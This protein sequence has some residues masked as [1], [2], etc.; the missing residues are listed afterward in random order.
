MMLAHSYT[1]DI[2]PTG[3][4][5]SEKMDGVR[6]YWDGTEL[7]SRLGNRIH[8]PKWFTDQ[9]PPY[10]HLDGELWG[11][12][13]NF[14][15]T[16]SIVRSQSKNEEWKHVHY[17]VFDSPTA[18]GGFEERLDHAHESIKGS[19]VASIVPQE[20]CYDKE[21]LYARLKA[22][23]SI[24]AEGLMLRAPAS[25]YESKR[26]HFLLKVKEMHDA[27]G[28]V[29]GHKQGAGKHSNRLGALWVRTEDGHE[30]GVGTGLSDAE[31]ESPPPIGTVITY[32]YQELTKDGIPRFPVFIR[33]REEV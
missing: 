25:P 4:L 21:H 28:T 31:R 17:W 6:A 33:V 1:P 27:E 2:D 10:I 16:I 19:Q 32:R 8:A 3:W 5:M 24:G 13:N 29:I 20:R 22:L 23:S 7:K 30:F 12:R 11:G 9:L 14:Q 26:S 15:R 18:Q